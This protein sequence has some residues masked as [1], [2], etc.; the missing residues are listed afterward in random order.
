[1]LNET[2]EIMQFYH[3]MRNTVLTWAFLRWGFHVC[4]L[5]RSFYLKAEIFHRRV[6]KK[7]SFHTF[8]FIRFDCPQ[9]IDWKRLKTL[10]VSILWRTISC[11]CPDDN[12]PFSIIHFEQCFRQYP[13]SVHFQT[14]SIV[15]NEWKV[16]K[17]FERRVDWTLEA[18][19]GFQFWLARAT[20]A[21]I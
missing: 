16:S 8:T 15:E 1:M 6:S 7:V 13:F 9:A 12:C 11:G 4:T 14:F 10:L 19:S 20:C 17:T 2:R 5:L 3:H 21:M 18:F